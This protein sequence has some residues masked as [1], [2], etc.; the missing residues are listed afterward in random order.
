MAS[1]SPPP[2][3]PIP[4]K[5]YGYAGTPRSGSRGGFFLDGEEIVVARENEVYKNRYKIIRV[6]VNSAV[7]EDTH[8]KNQ[9]TL[10]LVEES[11]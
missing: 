11:Q 1:S 3:P 6:G 10:A 2:P 8:N 4:L 5:F 9:Q 7:V